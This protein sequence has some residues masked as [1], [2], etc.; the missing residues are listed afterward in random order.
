MTSRYVNLLILI[1]GVTSLFTLSGCDDDPAEPDNVAVFESTEFGFEGTET[2]IKVTLSRAVKSDVSVTVTLTP[3]RVTYGTDFTTEPDGSSGSFDLTIPSGSAEASF[4]V[5]K[6]ATV[7]LNGNENITFTI[8]SVEAPVL[9]GETAVTKLSFSAITS[10]GAQLQLSGKTDASPYANSVYADLSANRQTPVDRKSWNLGFYSGSDFRVV[11]NH[12]YQATAAPTGKTDINAV[13]IADADENAASALNINFNP[14]AGSL[15]VVD[16]WRGDLAKTAFAPVS[17]VESE[18]KV[19]LVSFEG[20][21]DKDKWFKVKVNRNGDGYKVLYARVGETTIRTIDVPKKADYNF[22][23]ISLETNSIV[24]AE[25]MKQSWDIEWSYS[26]YDAGNNTP[27]WFQDF[28]LLNTLA[29][30]EAAEVLTSSVTYEAFG[31]A[32]ITGLTFLK[33]R[34]AIG[35]KWRST[36]PATGARTDRF[37]VIRDPLGNVYK[38]KFVSMGVGSDGGE[39][40]RPVIEYKLVKK[41]S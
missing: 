20:S 15:S 27:Y 33:T 32:N 13:T 30:A 21:K 39:R 25:P 29:G 5:I 4:K 17:A 3:E 1:I 31:E 23:F 9:Q 40:G 36:Q 6:P 34:D 8:T 10:E 24:S 7:F 19:Y 22:T 35:S 28:V 12:A 37:Y 11:L 26:T 41:A 38:L 2:E 14:G 18:N 16:D